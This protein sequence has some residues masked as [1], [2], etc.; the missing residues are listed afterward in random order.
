M[1]G[2]KFT[3]DA[4][5]G[6]ATV[7]WLEAQAAH[8]SPTPAEVAQAMLACA[9]AGDDAGL[10]ALRAVHAPAAPLGDCEDCGDDCEGCDDDDD[11]TPDEDSKVIDPQVIRAFI[12]H[13]MLTHPEQA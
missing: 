1:P 3:G 6:A 5:E 10:A 12:A 8:A 7:A 9:E 13:A 11:L 4:G 2:D